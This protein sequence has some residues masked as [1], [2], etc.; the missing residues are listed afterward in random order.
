VRAHV[1]YQDVRWELNPYQVWTG[2]VQYVGTLGP[3]TNLYASVGYTA[4]TYANGSSLVGGG[5]AAAGGYRDV[6]ETA[7]ATLQQQLFS[8][9]LSLALGGT[10]SRNQGLYGSRSASFTASLSWTKGKFSMSAGA[11]GSNSEVS[12]TQFLSSSREH[13][14]YYLR[15]QRRLF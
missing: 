5:S 1:Q 8:R 2:D 9:S 12:G 14:Y 6:S 11:S 3:T 15:L 4:R 13:R 7:A 10:V